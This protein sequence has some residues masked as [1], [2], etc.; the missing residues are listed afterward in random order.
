MQRLLLPLLLFTCII[1]PA[2]SSTK[3]TGAQSQW[4][5][6]DKN[7]KLVYKTTER[8]DRIM[9]FS[10]AGYMGGGVIL[11][12]VAVKKTVQPSGKEDD[13]KLVQDAIN[14]VSSLPLVNGSRGAV[15]LAPGTFNCSASI[16]I[17]ASGVVLRGSGS[18]EG[19]TTIKMSGGRHA[20]IVIGVRGNNEA[21]SS[22]PSFMSF[23]TTISDGYVPSGVNSFNVTD[24]SGFKKGD[25]IEIRKPVTEEWIRFMQM[26]KMTRDGKPQTW[27][28]AGSLLITQRTIASLAGNKITLD[29]PLS[30]C[31]D[32]AYTKP[33]GTLV[34]KIQPRNMVTQSAVEY[35]H[36]QSPP[37][38]MSYEQ[39]PYSALRINGRDC[40][41]RDIKIE[42][43][44]NSVSVGGSRITLERVIITR[45]VP[46]LGASKPAE[47]APNAGQ[48]LLDRC[49]SV[50]DNIWH[51]ATGAGQAGPIVLLNCTFGGSGHI[52]GHQRWTTGI[53]L[54]NCR[55]P[56]GGI[57]FKNRGS[58]G[59][60]HGWGTGWSVAWNCIAKQFVVQQPPGVYNW[61][62]G[63]T[64]PNIP[65]PQPFNSGPNLPLGISD[66]PGKPV[67]PQSLYLQ[68]LAERLGIKAL[69]NIGYSANDLSL[70][71]QPA[72]GNIPYTKPV[73]DKEFGRD[74][75]AY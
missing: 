58:M 51:A 66:S 64:G 9:D 22:D 61:M 2:Q 10:H 25:A 68:Q 73:I 36:I 34:A 29:V 30:D 37:M 65:T 24:A 11:P 50:G 44:M 42:E 27:I 6:P 54:D 53:L 26:D 31:I 16:T 15:M 5:Y 48:V 38:E 69:E 70:F 45:T 57:D 4:V 28:K 35:L 23:E 41:A 62:I 71:I 52:E 18:G 8:G 49:S 17:Q 21:V 14:E 20:A 59:S 63:C 1:S 56:E 74:F 43:T 19:G 55:I 72:P 33:N 32:A 7:G 40:W 46:N 3:N 67:T 39:A 60:G 75:A 13:T 12:S 47:F